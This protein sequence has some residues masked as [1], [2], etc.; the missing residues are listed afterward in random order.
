MQVTPH[1]RTHLW[2]YLPGTTTISGK[3]AGASTD[4]GSAHNGSDQP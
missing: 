3:A 1:D 4:P 2:G